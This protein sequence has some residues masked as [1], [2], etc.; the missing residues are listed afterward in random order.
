MKVLIICICVLM[1]TGCSTLCPQP[2]SDDIINASIIVP[3]PHPP[4]KPEFNFS[5]DGEKLN[6]SY[7]DGRELAYWILDVELYYDLIK[8]TFRE[9]E[10]AVKAITGYKAIKIE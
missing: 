2:D 3:Y 10:Q 9:I 1:I 8:L 5:S 6:L 4:T 7:E